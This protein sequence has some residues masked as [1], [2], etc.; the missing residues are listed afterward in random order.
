METSCGFVLVNHDCVLLLQYPQGHW[1]FVKGHYEEADGSY[2]QTALR[3]LREETGIED[4]RMVPDFEMRTE[5]VFTR[6]GREVR[7]QVFWFAAET[8]DLRQN[9]ASKLSSKGVDMIVANDVSAPGV[10][11]G[12][13]TNAVLL[14]DA[15][16][17]VV[18]IP[19]ADKRQIAGAVLDAALR[20]RG[21]CGGED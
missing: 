5:Y 3:E 14:L 1:G 2:Q 8:D 16:G 20:R 13:D 7:K 6:K 18:E 15:D 9:A 21:L 11:F 4:V 10:G 17:G 12:H 19:L